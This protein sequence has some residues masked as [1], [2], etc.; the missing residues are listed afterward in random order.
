MAI[1]NPEHLF[2][3]AERLLTPTQVG[4]PRQ[5]DIRRSIS[6]AYYAVFHA[7]LT[8]AAD[9]FVGTTK[10]SSPIYVLCYRS[11]AHRSLRELCADVR[12]STLPK[13]YSSYV[14]TNGLGPNIPTFASSVMELQEKR[15]TADYDPTFSAKISDARLTIRTARAALRRF[16]TAS[17]AERTAFLGILVFGL[18]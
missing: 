15:H 3:Q 6:N 12:K 9:T 4:A 14:P 18:H 10:R 17:I 7:I 2:E 8:E 1:I 5:V 13:K 11:I 16:Q